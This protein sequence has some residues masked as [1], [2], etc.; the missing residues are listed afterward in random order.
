MH[1]EPQF[2]GHVR[3]TIKTPG[4]IGGPHLI[5]TLSLEADTQPNDRLYPRINASLR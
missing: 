3:V 5:V 1:A 4:Q 2:D